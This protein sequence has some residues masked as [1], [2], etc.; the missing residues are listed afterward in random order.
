MKLFDLHCD[1][2]TRLLSE[3][4]GLYDNDLHI[5]LKRAG[6]LTSYAQVMAIWTD[7]RLSD[8][9]G[10]TRFLEV[11]EN[12]RQEI[13]LN[14]GRAVLAYS[15]KQIRDSVE[16]NISPLILAVEDARILKNDLSR[17]DVL[18]EC[19]VRILTLNW[20]GD[21]CIGGA[22]DTTHGLT[23]FGKRVVEKCFDIDIVP[24]ISHC[25]FKGADETI[26][27]AISHQKLIIASHSDSFTVNPHSRNLTD[28]HFM[29]IISLGGLVG[30]NL[31]PSHLSSADKADISDIMKH[32][33]HYLSLGGEDT[34]A[35][36]GD[37]D[38]T[39]LPNG[40]GGIEDM[41][42]LA[43]EM[44]RLNYSAKLTNKI[45]FENAFDFFKRIG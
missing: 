42:K 10:Y 18:R 22:H 21:T 5:S 26:D 38:G 45:L 28:E 6:Y 2:A 15:F 39:I 24:D 32:I 27:I 29:S 19:G 34:L 1:T 4:Q 17:L 40:F 37:L 25:S 36:G 12:L 16:H 23:K 30:L 44:Q 31:C 11:L 7:A 9:E 35:V 13:A 3:K 43:D 41:Y 8:N 33:E 14:Q 20:S